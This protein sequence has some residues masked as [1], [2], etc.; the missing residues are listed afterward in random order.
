MHSLKQFSQHRVT[1]TEEKEMNKHQRYYALHRE[2]KLSKYHSDPDVIAK[3][4]ERARKK[5]EKEAE[6]TVKQAEKE[7]KRQETLQ[8]ALATKKI[9]KQSND[10]L[11]DFLAEIPPV[12]K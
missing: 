5:A 4:E 12:V 7:R 2:Q 8:L 3:R 10:A 11:H 1:M 9:N 6:K